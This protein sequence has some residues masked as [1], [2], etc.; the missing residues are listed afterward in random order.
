VIVVTGGAGFLGRR[1][2]AALRERNQNVRVL[3][4][5]PDQAEVVKPFGVEVAYGDTRDADSL[6]RALEGAT[7]LIHLVA[8]IRKRRGATFRSVNVEGA[9]NVYSAAS[10]SGVRR[11]VFVSAI[12]AALRSPEPYFASRWEGEE[13]ARA[14][15]IPTT[16]VRFSSLFGEGDE[17]FN[18]MAALVK[19]APV[20]PIPGRGKTRFQPIHVE[21]AAQVCV[22]ALQDDSKIG[23]TFELGGPDVLTYQQMMSTVA[24]A[25]GKRRLQVPVPPAVMGPA[26]TAMSWLMETPP[27]T[28]DQFR[29][30]RFDS[31]GK[32]GSAE[33]EFRFK[34]RPLRG[35]IDFVRSVTYWDAVRI[36]LG[37]MPRHIRDH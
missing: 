20:V 32:P 22:R 8:V 35:N 11:S 37:R 12:G 15:G 33:S 13:E 9:R 30:L 27:V 29:M 24:R 31:V 7:G 25:M 10:V 34:P 19:V 5:R 17:F 1:V 26:V 6:N 16:V 14:S 4:R 23:R 28:P 36:M 3:I 2:V 18:V 21:D